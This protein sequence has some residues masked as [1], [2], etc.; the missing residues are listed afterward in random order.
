METD[1]MDGYPLAVSSWSA[2]EVAAI[3]Q[4]IRRDRFTM[5]DEV[6]AFEREFAEGHGSRYC[7]MVNSGSSANLLA[8]AS[9]FFRKDI[10][11][12][13]GDEVIVPAISWA[14]TFAPLQQYGLR[15]KL[16]DVDLETLNMDLDALEQ[17]IG[18]RT[19]LVFC[20]NL[21]GNPND[22]A[23]I[24]DIIAGRDVLL[25]EDNCESMG[26]EYEGR[27]TGTFG[28]LG[29]F[30]TFFSHHMSTMEGGLILTDDEEL[31]HLLLSLR[32][33]GWTR[34]LPEENSLVTK[35]TDPF[36]EEFRFIL[37]GYN[38]RPLEMS[39]AVGRVQWRKLPGFVEARRS[40][41]AYFRERFEG[42]PHLMIQR[43]IGSSSFFGFSLVIRPDSPWSRTDLIECMRARDIE[44]RPIV[45]GNFAAS[46]SIKW[47]DHEVC[48]ELSN[49]EHVSSH[50]FFVGNHHLDIRKQIDL[51][52]GAMAVVKE[53]SAGVRGS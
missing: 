24:Q 53:K 14:T 12:Q 41:A 37:P 4:V 9:L 30:S 3:Q 47:Y 22:F 34:S 16:I 2:D 42:H 11:L 39:G 43:E 25:I 31:Y 26:A 28:L 13:R 49:A 19:R 21:L 18:P 36:L 46:E 5:G 40:N 33:H 29:T 10:P 6:A 35:E 17:A 32:A 44:C 45:A 7:V 52:A 15:V 27:K 1:K 38:V 23:R 20:V 8:V 50:G 48:G 51:L